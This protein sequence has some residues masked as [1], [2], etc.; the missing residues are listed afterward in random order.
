MGPDG[1]LLPA[2]RGGPQV[3]DRLPAPGKGAIVPRTLAFSLK[4]KGNVPV[5]AG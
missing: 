1:D 3:V 5:R 2:I 4:S